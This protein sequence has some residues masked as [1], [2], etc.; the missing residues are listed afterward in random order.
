M[1]HKLVPGD[2]DSRR[3][4]HERLLEDCR[5]LPCLK[6]LLPC[7][8]NRTFWV[9]GYGS[10][11]WNPGFPHSAARPALL[12]GYHRRFCIWSHN[13][14]GT[15]ERPGLVLG[16]DRGGS[17]HGIAFCVD[18]ADS[19]PVLDYLHDREM[20]TRVYHPRLVTLYSAIGP[21]QGLAFVV[22][23]RH[24]QY[25][26]RLNLE[27]TASLIAD[28]HGQR[29]ACAEYLENT[30]DHLHA[31]SIEPGQLGPLLRLVQQRRRAM[32]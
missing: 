29:G 4:K 2:A 32:T 1:R 13:Y 25:T 28:A 14:R 7:R 11:M 3:H 5:D 8:V 24:Q 26:G 23:R 18:R 12:R 19:E 27:E 15:P 9:F 31:L 10:L 30:V 16:L 17:C 22:D 21:L 20:T 6:Q